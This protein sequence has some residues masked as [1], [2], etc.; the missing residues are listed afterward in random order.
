MW[1]KEA[2]QGFCMALA[3]SVPGVSGGSIAYLMGFYDKFITSL[4]DLT[5][6]D[7]ERRKDALVWLGKLGAGWAV[8]MGM[9]ATILS[10]LFEQYIY[11]VSSLFLGFIMI[12]VILMFREP[13]VL[14]HKTVSGFLSFLAGTALVIAVTA[15]QGI[16][17][18]S[19][20]LT[21][22]TLGGGV[23]LFASAMIA[24]SAM[25]LPGISGST[26]LLIFG[27]YLPVLTEVR[28]LVRLDFSGLGALAVFGLGAVTGIVLFVRW[29][30]LVLTRFPAQTKC[31]IIGLMM[32]SC[33]SIV[34]GPASLDIPK[35]PMSIR[36][37][38][39]LFFLMGILLVAA[40]EYPRK[41]REQGAG[42]KEQAL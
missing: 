29:I 19:V 42:A 31:A 26:L 18:G 10:S 35:D 23:Y 15:Q 25:V 17:H 9:A 4:N 6:R 1:I 39:P 12:A 2:F 40:L 20:D 34:M 37:F 21:E 33:Y 11:E 16:A 28:K 27:L 36:T 32:G 41:V 3:D 30:K 13:E 14:G 22:L 38:H 7:R 5:R 24:I 8:G